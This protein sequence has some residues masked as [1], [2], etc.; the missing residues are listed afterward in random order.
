MIADPSDAGPGGLPT[1]A[2]FRVVREIGRGGMG[3]VYEAIELA[4]G[5]RVALKLLA[6]ELSRQSTSVERFRREARAAARLHHTNIVPV[7]GVGEDAGT[8]Y[9]VMQFIEGLGLDRIFDRSSRPDQGQQ[10]TLLVPPLSH[11][12]RV[13]VTEGASEM[14]TGSSGDPT[15]GQR[16]AG[17]PTTGEGRQPA[18]SSGASDRS[19][20]RTVARIGWHVAEALTYAHGQGI[21]HRDVKPA[22]ILIDVQGSAWVA[23][24]GLAKAAEGEDGL[25]LSGDIVGTL[26]YMSPERIEGRSEVR[27]DVYALGATL[28][29]LITFRPL[30]GEG[31]RARLIQKILQEAPPRPRALDRS[32][33]RDLE[34]IVLKAI[35]KEPS[36]R[37]ATAAAMAED[38]RRYRAGEPILARRVGL[39]EQFWR[40]SRRNP[41]VASLLAALAMVLACGFSAMAVLW[42]KAEAGADAARSSAKIAD[43][44]AQSEAQIRAAS[45]LQSARLELDTGSLWARQGR[46]GRGLLWIDRGMRTAPPEAVNLRRAGLADFSA[47]AAAVVPS[48]TLRHAKKLYEIDLAPDGRTLVVASGDQLHLWDLETRTRTWAVDARGQGIMVLITADGRRIVVSSEYTGVRLLDA[49]SGAVLR[50]LTPKEKYHQIAGLTPDQQAVLVYS[51]LD[52]EASMISLVDGHTVGKRM[53]HGGPAEF[54][55]RPRRDACPVLG[56]G[57]QA[58]DLE[59]GHRRVGWPTPGGRAC[60]VP[61]FHASGQRVPRPGVER[62][63]CRRPRGA[64]PEGLR[65]GD[66]IASPRDPPAIADHRPGL[67][68]GWPFG[69]GLRAVRIGPAPR[70]RHRAR[71]RRHDP[72]RVTHRWERL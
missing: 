72:G 9:Y 40:W 33:P 12:V 18:P 31:N 56:Q 10:P 35:A 25:T 39:G 57:W 53:A 54:A 38:L 29:E 6:P 62:G 30:F 63:W 50:Q 2:G 32:I 60:D 71:S 7:F 15:E 55:P 66:G 14:A 5:R 41:Q 46:I 65:H 26:R 51:S 16:L 42:A 4:L 24:F 52:G 70:N 43:L 27:G 28:Y 3:V 64:D 69:P 58:S 13:E 47:W 20:F 19:H 61:F 1:I 68:A 23:D 49:A 36:A 8:C 34:T 67:P 11:P 48:A 37:Y 22:N 21:L 44:H 45:V 59:C 17:P